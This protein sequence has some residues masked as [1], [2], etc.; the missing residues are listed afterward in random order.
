MSTT[1]ARPLSPQRLAAARRAVARDIE[2]N[3]LTPELVQFRDPIERIKAWDVAVGEWRVAHVH[4]RFTVLM[5]CVKI[6][7]CFPASKRRAIVQYVRQTFPNDG[8]YLISY[9]RD[10][11][12][13]R[14]SVF[15]DLRMR[16]VYAMA[17]DGKISFQS[18]RAIVEA[19]K[20]S[21]A[22]RA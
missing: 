18:A 3:A 6:L 22:G 17:R 21:K 5:E 7:R 20:V 2:K 1:L 19:F 11:Q 4:T 10:V 15:R 12:T 14:T 8:T 9:I 13:G 16:G